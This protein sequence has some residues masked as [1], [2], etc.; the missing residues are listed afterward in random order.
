MER[1]I[2]HSH[3]QSRPCAA[4]KGRAH[5][6]LNMWTESSTRMDKLVSIWSLRCAYHWWQTK[7]CQFGHT[8]V[9]TAWHTNDHSAWHDVQFFVPRTKCEWNK[10]LN[11][12]THANAT[13]AGACLCDDCTDMAR[14]MARQLRSGAHSSNDMIC[15]SYTSTS[16]Y[17]FC[18]LYTVFCHTYQNY[19]CG[20]PHFSHQ[21]LLC[22]EADRCVD[23]FQVTWRWEPRSWRRGHR[24]QR[25]VGVPLVWGTVS[26]SEWRK[27]NLQVCFNESVKRIC[28]ILFDQGKMFIFQTWILVYIIRVSLNIQSEHIW[29]SLIPLLKDVIFADNVTYV[30]SCCL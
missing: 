19:A 1:H 10:T 26:V 18:I 23:L 6:C 14:D 21:A 16:L 8:T 28:L 30:T 27:R 2:I 5:C 4:Q 20:S 15:N 11:R 24:W 22:G 3:S 17:N 12:A 7:W 29:T 13:L 25:L 9:V